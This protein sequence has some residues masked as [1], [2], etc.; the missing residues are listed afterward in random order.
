[1]LYHK[2]PLVRLYSLIHLTLL[3]APFQH[4][5]QM[6]LR[7]GQVPPPGVPQSARYSLPNGVPGPV[8]SLP[9]THINGIGPG[10]QPSL[11]A[12]HPYGPAHPSAQPNGIPG[13]PPPP[14]GAPGQPFPGGMGGRPPL[15][16]QQRLPNGPQ[17]QSPTIAPSPQS[18]GNPPQPPAG[19]MGQLGRSPHMNSINRTAMPPPNGPQHPQGPGPGSAHPT[20]TPSYMQVGRPPSSHDISSQNPMNP[21]RSPA[22]PGRMPPG[23]DRS[24]MENQ[25]DA[26]LGSYP[27]EVIGDAKRHAG[28]GDRDTQSLSIDEK[29]CCVYYS[30]VAYLR[31][32]V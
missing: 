11:S 8:S 31:S 4:Q 24:H 23:H 12:P 29:V 13:P 25:I 21:H 26:E 32:V 28:L 18:H 27:P 10:G 6:K 15:G 16:P 1:M 22:M 14:P 2:V 3:F 17:Y 5:N 20:P 19:A 7:A 30:A 9:G